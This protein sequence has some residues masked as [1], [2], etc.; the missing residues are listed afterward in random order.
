MKSIERLPFRQCA[1]INRTERFI[2]LRPMSGYS[3]IQPEDDGYAIYLPLDAT[4]EG[5]GRALLEAWTEAGLFGR[6]MSPNSSNGRDM[7]NAIRIGIRILCVAMAIKPNVRLT[8]AWTGA[9]P[10]GRKG[11]FQLRRAS[12]ISRNTSEAFQ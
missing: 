9:A 7:R 4:D 10:R 6:A 2:C 3:M 5:L 1:D 8:R 11:R 12:G